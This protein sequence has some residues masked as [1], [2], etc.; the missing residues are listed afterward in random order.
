MVWM[1]NTET[2]I[3]TLLQQ[4]LLAACLAQG[5]TQLTDA[6]L[7]EETRT[8]VYNLLALGASIVADEAAG[9]I[10]VAGTAGYWPNIDAELSCE[11]SFPLACLLIC[12]SCVGRG[13]Y[14]VQYS[15][16]GKAETDAIAVLLNALRDLGA[17]LAMDTQDSRI[18]VNIGAAI[19]RGGRVSLPARCPSAVLLSLL[20]V[21]PYAVTDVFISHEVST[22]ELDAT[23]ELMAQFGVTPIQD[24][25]RLIVPAPQQYRGP[26][27]TAP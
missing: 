21:S 23:I 4:S 16:S 22:T 19:L 15:A 25:S 5:R 18:S 14:T 6:H 3:P 1:Q 7:D 20:L 27:N 17:V 10:D 13:Q 26:E 11:A 2:T 8:L 12:A 9:R 24:G